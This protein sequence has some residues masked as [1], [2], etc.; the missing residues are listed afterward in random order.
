M[1]RSLCF[2]VSFID[3]EKG[4]NASGGEARYLRKSE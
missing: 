2:M 4:V 3:G 1:R